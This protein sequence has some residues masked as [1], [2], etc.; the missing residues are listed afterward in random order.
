MDLH[1]VE[2]GL[3]RSTGGSGKSGYDGRNIFPAR[4]TARY[5]T[6]LLDYGRPYKL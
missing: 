2:S 1:G 4:L 5:L 3:L 6:I